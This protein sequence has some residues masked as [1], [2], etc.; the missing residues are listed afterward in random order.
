MPVH[1]M[2]IDSQVSCTDSQPGISKSWAQNKEFDDLHIPHNDGM[3]AKESEF[4]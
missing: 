3:L 1:N 2:P 4:F